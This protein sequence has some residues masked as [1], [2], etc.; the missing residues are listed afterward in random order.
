LALARE[1][2]RMRA[3]L[4]PRLPEIDPG[5]LVMILHCLLKPPGQ[6]VVFARQARSG[7]HVF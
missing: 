5:D 3:E 1:I 7:V 4:A 2:E 6:R